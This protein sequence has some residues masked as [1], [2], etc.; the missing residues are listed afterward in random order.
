MNSTK[1]NL[2]DIFKIV[3]KVKRIN[4]NFDFKNQ[5]KWDSLSHVKLILAL[6]SKFKIKIHPDISI[7]LLSYKKIF[8]FIKKTRINQ[9]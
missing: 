1:K 2:D 7:N 8:D 5:K 9:A 4:K 6:E 3:F